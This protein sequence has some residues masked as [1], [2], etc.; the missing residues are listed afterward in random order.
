V[1]FIAGLI[2]VNFYP[3]DEK[4]YEKMMKDAGR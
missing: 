4:T 3:L 2:L 1:I